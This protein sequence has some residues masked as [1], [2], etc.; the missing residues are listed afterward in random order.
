MFFFCF[1]DEDIAEK[2]THFFLTFRYLFNDFILTG[3]DGFS[4]GNDLK[5]TKTTSVKE[6]FIMV[7][8][9]LFYKHN[10]NKKALVLQTQ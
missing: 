3:T 5:Y 2:I 10:T 8:L 6:I 1:S 9:S 4:P 7:L